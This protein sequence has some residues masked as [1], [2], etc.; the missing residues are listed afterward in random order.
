MDLSRRFTLAVAIAAAFA[1]PLVAHAGISPVRAD[2]LLTEGDVLAGSVVS[3]LNPV[4]TDGVGRPGSIVALADGRRLI[5][6]D[7]AIVFDSGTVVDPV[8]S[9]GES[10][11]G[12]GD[13]GAFIY[14]PSIDGDD[15]VWTQSGLLLLDGQPDPVVPGQFNAFNSRPSM[16]PDGRAVWVAG[17]SLT[18][19]GATAGRALF[20]ATTGATPVF[21]SLLR[22]GDLIGG[23]AIGTTG[24]T[25]TYQMSDSGEHLAVV[26]LRDTGS[27]QTDGSVLVDGTI[28]AEEGAAVGP[29]APGENWQGFAGVAINDAG[30]WLLAGDTSGP[31]ATDAFLAYNGAIQVREGNSLGGEALPDGSALRAISINNLGQ[32]V[33]AWNTPGNVR[34]LFFA[35]DAGNLPDSVL[36][37]KTGTPL[38]L[39]GNGSAEA[40]LVDVLGSFTT[41][42]GLSLAE[43]GSVYI[44]AS[45]TIDG[46]PFESLLRLDGV[47]VIFADGFDP[48]GP[49]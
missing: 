20:R 4:F 32:A 8:L 34:K 26:L 15:A 9:G 3:G 12:I 23:A 13:G 17:Y 19:G 44:Q 2:V 27:T 36:L 48:A 10:T 40:V 37:L 47:D 25:F 14:S 41:T 45:Y 33:H 28:R 39:D 21:E 30:D 43:D 46:S 49:L 18:A 6:Y 24:I 1:P 31:T 16:L 38:D 35:N 7:G 5:W 11:I 29:A 42:T 22:T